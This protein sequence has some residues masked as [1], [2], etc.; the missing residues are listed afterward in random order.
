MKGS[1]SILLVYDK[2]PALGTSYVINFVDVNKAVVDPTL[3]AMWTVNASD[4]D[5]FISRLKAGQ[6][7][8]T[9]LVP[10]GGVD[11]K[12]SIDLVA[13]NILEPNPPATS[14]PP[15]A[16]TPAATEMDMS[17]FGITNLRDIPSDGRFVK[18]SGAAPAQ[19]GSTT[20]ILGAAVAVLLLFFV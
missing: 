10:S 14:P 11:R 2:P 16:S 7:A 3:N 4:V 15:P 9:D 17:V 18:T 13:S 1:V 6:F 19:R 12:I 5:S 20:I 8:V